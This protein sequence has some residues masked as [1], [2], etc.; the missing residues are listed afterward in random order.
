MYIRR[1]LEK[2]ILEISEASEMNFRLYDWGRKSEDRVLM[3]E[4]ALDFIEYHKLSDDALKPLR[5][6]KTPDQVGG[7][8]KAPVMPGSAKAGAS[9]PV[10]PGSASAKAGASAPVMPGS[11]RASLT[12]T[13]G[14][15]AL[16]PADYSDFFL[17]PGRKDTVLLEAYIAR[18][19][20][21]DT[22][23]GEE[24]E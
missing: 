5:A 3:L 22:Y 23:H 19:E 2:K 18:T 20:P 10:M 12:L 13:A 15:C 1:S 21:D 16:I 6:A 11:D 4:D 7:D 24:P 14:T 9:D 8:G 17:V